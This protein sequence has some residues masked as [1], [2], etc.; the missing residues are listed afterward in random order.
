VALAGGLLLVL[1]L[2][3][4]LL[5]GFDKIYMRIIPAAGEGSLSALSGSPETVTDLQ[6]RLGLLANG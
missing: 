5:G 1:G 6:N 2:A 4:N 3:W